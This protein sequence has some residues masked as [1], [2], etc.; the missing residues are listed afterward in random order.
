MGLKIIMTI[1]M[2]PV[3]PILYGAMR[4]CAGE[5]RGILY[6]VTLWVGAKEERQVQKIQKAYRR[7]LNLWAL[8]CL[9][10]FLLTLVTEHESLMISGQI[11]WI[12]LVIILLFLPFKRA[13]QQ[14]MRQKREFLFRHPE[15]EPVGS[16][17]WVDVKI[18]RAH[19]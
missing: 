16:K 6:G 13:N 11:L 9:L 8:V 12:F 19:V 2:L 5:K 3:L 14:M 10:L 17:V 4:F 15:N 18:G 1:C 7:E